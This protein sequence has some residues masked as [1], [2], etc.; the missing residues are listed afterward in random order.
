MLRD[1]QVLV[2][3]WDGA[4]AVRPRQWDLDRHPEDEHRGSG[5]PAT[6]LSDGR[7]FVAGGQASPPDDW[8]GGGRDLRPR[9][10]VLD[11]IADMQSGTG[12]SLGIAT[13]LPDGKVL[14]YSRMGSEIYD[15][16]TG[17]W[18]ARTRQGTDQIPRHCCQTAPC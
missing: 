9:H 17:T 16:T 3:W 13:Q 10:G 14:V 4:P 18:T 7:V 6:L 1:G 8:Y 15:P 5:P 12:T 11:Q 2:T